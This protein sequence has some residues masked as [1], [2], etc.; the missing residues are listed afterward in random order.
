VNFVAIIIKYNFINS[1]P[2]FR[3]DCVYK[4]ATKIAAISLN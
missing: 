2:I 4:F 3:D 1:S